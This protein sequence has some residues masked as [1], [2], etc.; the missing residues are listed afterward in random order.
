MR[1][2]CGQA[3]QDRPLLFRISHWDELFRIHY[4]AARAKGSRIRL[5]LWMARMG[6]LSKIAT[7]RSGRIGRSERMDGWTGGANWRA[8]WTGISRFRIRRGETR[9][10]ECENEQV[11]TIYVNDGMFKPNFALGS[12]VYEMTNG[13]WKHGAVRR[14]TGPRTEVNLVNSRRPARPTDAVRSSPAVKWSGIF[15]P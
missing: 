5:S 14:G 11:V 10:E 2:T 7:R 13:D 12:G 4:T 3:S 15:E 6:I 8:F 1:S 9:I